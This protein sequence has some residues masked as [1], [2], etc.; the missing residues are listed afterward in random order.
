MY[1]LN[2]CSFENIANSKQQTTEVD[3]NKYRQ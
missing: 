2:I 1:E 3:I